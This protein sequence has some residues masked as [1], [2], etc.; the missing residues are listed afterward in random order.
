[1]LEICPSIAGGRVS[2]EA[3]PLGIGGKADPVRLVFTAAAGPAVVLSLVD[4][5]ERLRFVANEV[6]AIEPPH[7]LPK[8]PVARALWRPRPDLAT[9]AEAWL[10]AGGSHHT[11]YTA[12][13][14]LET[15]ADFAEIAGVELLPVGAETRL[16][17]FAN[18]VRWNQAYHHLA[19][20]L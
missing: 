5:G 17:D 13:L 11:V 10:T 3:H 6:D 12:A 20:S 16:R 19:R 14:G 7:A 4:L 8:L 15:V 1:M 2:C 9:A 18:E